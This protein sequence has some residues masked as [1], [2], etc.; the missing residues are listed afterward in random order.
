MKVLTV[1]LERISDPI[2]VSSESGLLSANT[3]VNC[4]NVSFNKMTN[5]LIECQ[6]KILYSERKLNKR[7]QPAVFI[8]SFTIIL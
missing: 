4:I 1:L 7:F 8:V 5:I 6:N 2:N 3:Y